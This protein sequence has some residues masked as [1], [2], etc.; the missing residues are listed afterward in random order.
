MDIIREV[1]NQTV[2][3]SM[4]VS[5]SFLMDTKEPSKKSKLQWIFDVDLRKTSA[6][7]YGSMKTEIKQLGVVLR[8]LLMK[9]ST[10]SR[11]QAGRWNP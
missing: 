11:K 6:Q 1:G 7:T 4:K 10:K 3:P 8:I 9:R 2:L 5:I